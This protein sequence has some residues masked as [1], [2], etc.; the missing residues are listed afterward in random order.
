MRMIM[1]HCSR[2]IMMQRKK[3]SDNNDGRKIEYCE[4]ELDSFDYSFIIDD[5]EESKIKK[6]VK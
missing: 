4:F 2:L 5:D 1:E 6:G 3:K